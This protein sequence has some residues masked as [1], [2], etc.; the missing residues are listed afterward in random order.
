MKIGILGGLAQWS[1]HHLMLRLRSLFAYSV[2]C[3]LL[4]L[5]VLVPFLM[6]RPGLPEGGHVE[7]TTILFF[8]LAEL[9]MWFSFIRTWRELSRRMKKMETDPNA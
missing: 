7:V 2:G 5:S 8:G 3:F 9:C 6:D 1:T 4:M